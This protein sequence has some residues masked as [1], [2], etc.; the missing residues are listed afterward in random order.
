MATSENPL[1]KSLSGH[2]G[3]QLIIRQYGNKTV[4]STFPRKSSRKKTAKQQRVREMMEEANYEAKTIL[5]DENLRMEAQV[6]L[7]VTRNRLYTALVREYFKTHYTP[8]QQE[9]K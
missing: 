5:A 3:R 2:L 4:V 9:G 6:R 8:D 1:L 7:N